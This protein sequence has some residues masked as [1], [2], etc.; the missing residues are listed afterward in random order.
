MALFVPVN[1]LVAALANGVHNLA[2]DSLV[3]ALTNAANP[4]DTSDA[5]LTD[6]VQ[7]AYTNL[8]SRAITTT[9]STQT[10]GV[11]RLILADLVLTASGAVAAFRYGVIYNDTAT[12]DEI[13]GFIDNGSDVTLGDTETFTFDFD[14][15][16]G[17][18]ALDIQ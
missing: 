8:S 6:I 14:G 1:S 4:P 2:S 13:L 11:H 9:S 7:I 15:T 12:N 16:N 5:V 17:I 3:M 10:A 18:W